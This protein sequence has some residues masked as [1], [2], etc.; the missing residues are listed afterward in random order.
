MASM[1][2]INMPACVP[3]WKILIM[4]IPSEIHKKAH[5][6][7]TPNQKCLIIWEDLTLRALPSNLPSCDLCSH[8]PLFAKYNMQI[9]ALPFCTC[10]MPPM[11]IPAEQT[12]LFSIMPIYLANTFPFWPGIIMTVAAEERSLL[13]N[14][15]SGSYGLNLRGQGVQGHLDR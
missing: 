3:P 15:F 11:K 2:V 6:S 4:Y 12:L 7:S 13:S 5:V 9:A 10:I 8:P 1:S 14:Y